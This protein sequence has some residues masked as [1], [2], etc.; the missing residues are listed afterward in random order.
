[1]VKR[2]F[3]PGLLGISGTI[4]EILWGSSSSSSSSCS[5]WDEAPSSSSSA[6]SNRERLDSLSAFTFFSFAIFFIFF[7]FFFFLFSSFSSCFS[8]F[9][10]LDFRL[11]LGDCW[12]NGVLNLLKTQNRI[13]VQQSWKLPDCQIISTGWMQHYSVTLPSQFLLALIQ[14]PLLHHWQLESIFTLLHI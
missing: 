11:V 3:V 8:G 1:M 2:R 4:G 14:P 5:S 12:N 13:V 7:F 6:S 9:G 10:F